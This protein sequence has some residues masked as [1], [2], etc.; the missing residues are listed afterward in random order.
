MLKKSD[1]FSQ[2]GFG[3][4]FVSK[5]NRFIANNNYFQSFLPGPGSYSVSTH[6]DSLIGTST[7]SA[8]KITDK[9]KYQNLSSVF[10][11]KVSTS[12]LN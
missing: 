11:P 1:S 6:Q 5:S 3:N 2:K 7:S 12:K 10:M 4:G 8:F 9:Y